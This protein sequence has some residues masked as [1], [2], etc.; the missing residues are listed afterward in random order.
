LFIDLHPPL[1]PPPLLLLLLFLS[2]STLLQQPLFSD[3]HFTH[4]PQLTDTIMGAKLLRVL[5]IFLVLLALSTLGLAAYYLIRF[6]ISISDPLYWYRWLQL[7]LAIFSAIT[8]IWALWAP[9]NIIKWNGIHYIGSL[10]LA[11]AWLVCPIYWIILEFSYLR[12]FALEDKFFEYWSC[13]II[14]G[15]LCK[16]RFAADICGFVMTLFVLLEVILAHRDERSSKAR[17]AGTL[18]T[19]VVAGPGPV[20]QYPAQP[21]QPAA[22]YYPQPGMTGPYQPR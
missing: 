11:A 5:R 6:R 15:P 10:I 22:Y 16:I 1:L 9:K 13:N 2:L 20:Q 3:P 17:K 12:Q 18:P 4:R 14:L 7:F 19:T 8:Y 21:G